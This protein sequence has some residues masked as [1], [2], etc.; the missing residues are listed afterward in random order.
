MDTQEIINLLSEVITTV[1]PDMD[2]SGVGPQSRLK[3][4]MGLDSL[5]MILIAMAIENK[6]SIHFR[7]TGNLLT[8]DDICKYI[9]SEQE[10]A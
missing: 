7:P 4:D 1:K 9:S 6:F 5:N 3:E 10:K 8:V 2:L